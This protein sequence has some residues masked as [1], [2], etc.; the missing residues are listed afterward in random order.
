MGYKLKEMGY[1]HLTKNSAR[2]GDK[3]ILVSPDSHYLIGRT[4]PVICSKYE[5]CGIIDSVD[6]SI[7]SVI[8]YNGARNGYVDNELVLA[9]Y[10]KDIRAVKQNEWSNKF[11]LMKQIV[12]TESGRYASIW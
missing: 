8:W 10:R 7:I 12:K 1:K 5:C 9:K 3:V 2:V 4:N 11:S 6:G